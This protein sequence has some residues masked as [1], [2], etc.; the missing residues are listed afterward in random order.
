MWKLLKEDIRFKA[1]IWITWVTE[2]RGIPSGDYW[3]QLDP[4]IPTFRFR[5]SPTS[6]YILVCSDAEVFWTHAT[7]R[8]LK[9]ALP[10]IGDILSWCDCDEPNAD[11]HL[12]VSGVTLRPD[13]SYIINTLPP[14]GANDISWRA[15][16]TWTFDLLAFVIRE[17]GQSGD[18][19]QPLVTKQRIPG[20]ETSLT[21]LKCGD[22]TEQLF[23]TRF[24][25]RCE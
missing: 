4:S 12:I 23:L 10:E 20:N 8:D 22:A 1:G 25:P 15:E 11:E 19:I 14:P 21:C 16:Q 17:R 5:L 2:G 18:L 9:E 24:C 6:K 7:P 3:V 13:N